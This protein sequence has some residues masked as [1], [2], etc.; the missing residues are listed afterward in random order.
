MILEVLMAFIGVISF[1]VILGVPKSEYIFAGLTG[2]IGR[3]AFI[4][5]N[6]L[7]GNGIYATLFASIFITFFSR[8]FAVHRRVPAIVYLRGGVFPLVPG[9][10]IYY[11]AYYIFNHE[12][13]LASAA[14]IDAISQALALALG[15]MIA[16]QIPQK[17]FNFGKDVGSD[18][19]DIKMSCRERV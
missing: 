8:L 16:S 5:F 18:G 13:G 2:A 11:T 1:S 15:I 9:A 17:F 3:A 4:I 6:W 10:G 14:G 19:E 7:L 12:T